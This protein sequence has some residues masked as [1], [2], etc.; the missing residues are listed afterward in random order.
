[1]RY[2]FLILLNEIYVSDISDTGEKFMILSNKVQ[3]ILN[4][5]A[6][7]TFRSE[8]K[9]LENTNLQKVS[10]SFVLNKI[11]ED[12]AVFMSMKEKKFSG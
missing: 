1:M 8:K 7:E 5:S 9:R 12:Y 3:A 4:P 11:L 10:D 6:A 2:M